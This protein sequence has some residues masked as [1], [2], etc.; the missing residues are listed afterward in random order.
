MSFST[1]LERWASVGD[2][3]SDFDQKQPTYTI[4][5]SNELLESEILYRGVPVVDLSQLS[6]SNICWLRDASDH[7]RCCI[8]HKKSFLE[9]SYKQLDSIFGK[10]IRD[11]QYCI[12]NNERMLPNGIRVPV[13]PLEFIEKVEGRA[14][15]RKRKKIEKPRVKKSQLHHVNAILWFF[16]V[17]AAPTTE[18]CFQSLLVNPPRI[19]ARDPKTLPKQMDGSLVEP[20]PIEP[21]IVKSQRAVVLS[22]L[23]ST[24]AVI[25]KHPLYATQLEHCCLESVRNMGDLVNLSITQSDGTAVQIGAEIISV[26]NYLFPQ[27]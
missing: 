9:L 20:L 4:K 26:Y 5:T 7:L 18:E 21:C 11:S 22:A 6:E 12:D 1:F 14:S 23:E 24:R 8:Y 19:F 3:T 25:S 2:T 13:V 16:Y 10:R 15:Q 17:G 27:A